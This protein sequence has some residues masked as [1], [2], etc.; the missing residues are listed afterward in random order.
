MNTL[1]YITSQL[2]QHTSTSLVRAEFNRSASITY[3][4][5]LAPRA[6]WQAQLWSTASEAEYE[7]KRFRQHS[8]CTLL[9]TMSE[10]R[11]TYRTDPPTPSPATVTSSL[12]EQIPSSPDP[13]GLE[14]AT[15]DVTAPTA[16]KRKISDDRL[17]QDLGLATQQST[18]GN[19]P[20]KRILHNYSGRE[21]SHVQ[22][23]RASLPSVACIGG[24]RAEK[25]MPEDEVFWELGELPE[26]D[27]SRYVELNDFTIYRP[28]NTKRS[29]EMCTL[30]KL[31]TSKG[32]DRLI[33]S[34]VLSKATATT[35][36]YVNE[37]PFSTLAIDGYGDVDCV[38]LSG[39]ICIQSVMAQTKPA[40]FRLGKPSAEYQRFHNEFVWLA[41]F[42]KYFADFLIENIHKSVTLHLFRC[43]FLP[44]L[45]Q[46]Y[47]SV[48]EFQSWHQLCGFQQ[49]FGTSVAAWV[50]YLHKECYSINDDCT[51][52]LQHP[53]WQ[54]IGPVLSAIER[55]P[56]DGSDATVVTPFVR[57]CF[58]NMYFA[59][60]LQTKEP[61]GKVL[62]TITRCKRGLR[63]TPWNAAPTPRPYLSRESRDTLIVR[64][65]D[66]VCV[67]PNAN[68]QWK[69][70]KATAWYA[71][72]QWVHRN[73]KGRIKLDV[74]W[75]YE[76]SDTTLGN[77]YY[78]FE[79]ELFLSDNCSCGRHAIPLESVVSKIDVSWFA[80]DPHATTGYFVRF[81][82]QTV[83]QEDSYGFITLRSADFSC[84]ASHL[85]S[86]EACKAYYEVGQTVLVR[87]LDT[88][89]NL[90]EPMQITCF[91]ASKQKVLLKRYIRSSL[92]GAPPNELL[93]SNQKAELRATRIVRTCEVRVFPSRKHVH[94]PYNRNGSGDFFYTLESD[95]TLQTPPE[96]GDDEGPTTIFA[97]PSSW[98][99]SLVGLDLFS[100]G[101]NFG[102]GLEEGGAVKMRYAVDWNT[103][104]L[105]SYRANTKPEDVQYFLG[106]VNHHLSLTLLGSKDPR[107]AIVGLIDFISGGSPC[108]GFSTMQSNKQSEQSLSFASMVASTVAYVD[109]YNPQYFILENVVPMTYKIMVNGQEQNV[110]SQILAS[111]V[112][113]GYQVQQFLGESWSLGSSQQRSRV[114]IVASAPGTVPLVHPPSTHGHPAGRE[115]R[116]SLGKTTN[117][118]SFGIRRYED[119]PFPYVS[120]QEATQDLPDVGDSLTQICPKF[121]DHRTHAD[122]SWVTRQRLM[123][124][125]VRPR[126]MGLVQAVESGVIKP[127][128]EAYEWFKRC[129]PGSI[130]ANRNS[131]S[132]SRIRPDSLFPTVLTDL[133]LQCGINGVVLHWEQHRSI[134][135]MET[136]R[137]Q[138]FLDHEVIL[139]TPA[140]QLKIVGNSVDRKVAFAMGLIIKESWNST[141]KQRRQILHG[142][143]WDDGKEPQNTHIDNVSLSEATN[144]IPERLKTS[145]EQMRQEKSEGLKAVIH[146]LQS[147][148]LERKPSDDCDADDGLRW[149][150]TT[151]ADAI[152]VR[153]R[154]S[155]LKQALHLNYL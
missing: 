109:T 72:V 37:I 43:E 90:L 26:V 130:R 145:R 95:S 55:Q 96:S 53:I 9:A 77:A 142:S 125:P 116:R 85:S 137:A 117:G 73:S 108:P 97:A 86:F 99:H 135:I 47:G 133:H 45:V 31:N 33:F 118:L 124:I 141:I 52:L 42:A 152:A 34:G 40:W 32:V 3:P 48:T 88:K 2:T 115:V 7:I 76:P 35:S 23:P 102:R 11:I 122:Q 50:N 106:S 66:V 68:D 12:K 94:L 1:Q 111:L 63:L 127:G 154:V 59:S 18:N 5:T 61:C 30:D 92:R 107:V 69:R 6:Q 153:R 70:S 51:K 120:A 54:E 101:G 155:E 16:K 21:L 84:H 58:D 65:G 131:K 71:Y 14:T 121:P 13:I 19:P 49:E 148:R 44:W 10:E 139:G 79:N 62:A 8:H 123:Q 24:H 60:H 114:F 36:Y 146:R 149:S 74:L 56:S 100:G 126:G 136:R 80:D 150:G 39:K 119:T 41:T 75:L 143:E 82:F 46:Q 140:Q 29:M 128:S 134:T 83:E 89:D 28:A 138:G 147:K 25:T 144:S 93:T 15:A 4:S 113:L 27:G 78:P 112:A 38:S 57:R 110:F 103:E 67:S 132:Y 129:K 81:K 98:A 104:A 151:Q 64:Q 17:R 91:D 87:P 105:H 22:I 20:S